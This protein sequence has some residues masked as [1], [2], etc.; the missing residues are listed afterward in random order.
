MDAVAQA[1]EDEALHQ[2]ADPD[3]GV[4][5]AHGG[6]AEDQRCERGQR[7]GDPAGANAAQEV[8]GRFVGAMAV[9]PA[10]PAAGAE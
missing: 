5:Q 3:R 4:A 7:G 10:T 1:S 8:V 2:R 6:E 9:A